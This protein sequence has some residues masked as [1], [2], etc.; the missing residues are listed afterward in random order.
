MI[1]VSDKSKDVP[2]KKIYIQLYYVTL[3]R[4]YVPMYSHGG[5]VS[6]AQ[7]DFSFLQYAS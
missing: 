1:Y 4:Q 2:I 5:Y 7:V 3:V 6:I